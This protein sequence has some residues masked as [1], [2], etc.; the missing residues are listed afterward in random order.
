M[1]GIYGIITQNKDNQ[2]LFKERVDK[3]LSHRGRDSSGYYSKRNV[4]IGHKRLAITGDHT[5]VQPFVRNQVILS[6]NGE[7]YDFEKVKTLN[8]KYET[9]SDNE[10]ILDLYH[11][12]KFTNDFFERLNG[13]FAFCLY[14]EKIGK[15]YL[16]RDRFGI[17]PLYY[18]KQGDEFKFASEMKSLSPKEF[19]DK[20]LNQ[21]LSHQYHDD[22]VTMFKDIYQVP[23]GSYLSLD[24][25]TLNFSV[26]PYWNIEFNKKTDI[27]LDILTL[28]KESVQ[29]RIPKEKFAI[30]LSGGI[31]SSI[32]AYLTRDHNP[33]SYTVAFTDDPSFN[34]SL[35]A[36]QYAKELGLKHN[37]INLNHKDL[38]D[39]LEKSIKVSEEININAHV[40]A[41]NLLMNKISDKYRIVLSG[42]GSDEFFIGYSHFMK[43]LGLLNVEKNQYLTGM[44]LSNRKSNDL[45]PEFIKA[46]LEIGLRNKRFKNFN[47]N[48]SFYK[49]V[50]SKLI[51]N[52]V[53]YWSK[54]AL[55]NY[56]L[57]GLGDK[58][59]M[60]YTIEG[61]I[62]FLDVKLVNHL[63][64]LE[65]KSK[66]SNGVEKSLLK[67]IF[68][69]KLPDYIL[70]KTKHPFVSPNVLGYEYSREFLKDLINSKRTL[71][72]GYE[73][74]K[75]MQEIGN[76]DFEAS[77]FI[78]ISLFFLKDLFNE[79]I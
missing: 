66:V 26:I 52:S 21:V 25:N 36:K 3:S 69:N 62:P 60:S 76:K 68:K 17:K 72:L 59:E 64:S 6:A 19:S 38:I 73:P 12:Y 27:S 16:V 33:E 10:L 65:A 18:T 2:I 5:G 46:K 61:R 71:D 67:E 28:L 1:C 47:H 54:M 55:N 23:P 75:M 15:L 44:H 49:E 20:A 4:L 8:F 45:L 37:I 22:Q 78:F 7:L 63:L 9:T 32:I 11:N 42:E 48:Q 14:D 24:I 30:T 39:N 70:N 51:N 74:N 50:D 53:Y 35:M 31:D 79:S 43:D 13:E 40:S 34:E 77:F 57:Q 58:Q 41:K 56:I 29:R